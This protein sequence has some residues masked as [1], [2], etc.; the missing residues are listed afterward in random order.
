MRR[1][2]EKYLADILDSCRFLLDFTAGRTNVDFVRKDY[3]PVA[4]ISS[5]KS[6]LMGNFLPA[7]R[8]SIAT[9]SSLAVVCRIT[10][11]LISTPPSGF[12]DDN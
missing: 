2:P 6:V 9:I 3:I 10:L 1:D 4:A 5:L 11:S 7:S 12:F 8:I